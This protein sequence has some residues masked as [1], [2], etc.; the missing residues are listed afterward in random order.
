[1]I[2]I[3]KIA[4][5]LVVA[6]VAVGCEVAFEGDVVYPGPAPAKPTVPLK[7]RPIVPTT[8]LPRPRIIDVAE[9]TDGSIMVVL[10]A[11]V[12]AAMVT[13]TTFETCMSECCVVDGNMFVLQDVPQDTFEIMIEVDGEVDTYKIFE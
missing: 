2:K 10:S 1:M 4:I 5:C 13:V 6:L 3:L 8:K 9:R 12:S 11:E 7:K